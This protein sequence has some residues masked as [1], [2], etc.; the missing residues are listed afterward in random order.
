MT[1]Q[2]NETKCEPEDV[3][4]QQNEPAFPE[5]PCLEDYELES[6]RNSTNWG[7]YR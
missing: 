7:E 2:D 1:E 4:P 3:I 6:R 5:L